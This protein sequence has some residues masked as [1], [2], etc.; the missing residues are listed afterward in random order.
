MPTAGP[1]AAVPGQT[2]HARALEGLLG[3][4]GLEGGVCPSR[5]WLRVPCAGPGLSLAALALCKGEFCLT[6][7]E[8][9]SSP[10]RCIT[11]VRGAGC[12]VLL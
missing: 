4:E 10:E 11:S 9:F 6:G 7:T 2:P 3:V 5:T 1:G 12:S 8:V